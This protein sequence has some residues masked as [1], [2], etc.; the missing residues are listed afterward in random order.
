MDNLVEKAKVL[1]IL[2]IKANQISTL[3]PLAAGGV[4]TSV[5]ILDISNQAL[6]ICPPLEKGK[7]NELKELYLEKK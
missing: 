5:T 1:G 7:W 2:E 4:F 3:I 6:D